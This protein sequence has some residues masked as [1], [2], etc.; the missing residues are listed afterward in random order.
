MGHVVAHVSVRHNNSAFPEPSAYLIF[1]LPAVSCIKKRCQVGAYRVCAAKFTFQIFRDHVSK[2]GFAVLREVGNIGWISLFL[3]PF[4]QEFRLHRFTAAVNPRKDN[5]SSLHSLVSGWLYCYPFCE[6]AYPFGHPDFLFEDPAISRLHFEPLIDDTDSFVIH[7]LTERL[8]LRSV[9]DFISSNRGKKAQK[10]VFLVSLFA[11]NQNGIYPTYQRKND[12]LR[13]KTF[14]RF[15]E[16]KKLFAFDASVILY[17]HNAIRISQKYDVVLP[18]PASEGLGSQKRQE[19]PHF[20]VREFIRFIDQ[21]FR[22]LHPAGKGATLARMTMEDFGR[23]WKRIDEMLG[24]N[25]IEITPLP[26]TS[27]LPGCFRF[28]DGAFELI[29]REFCRKAYIASGNGLYNDLPFG[30]CFWCKR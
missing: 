16:D 22:G 25:K 20:E 19:A 6:A 13:I 29:A 1:T 18:I 23:L 30:R 8:R 11:A 7:I 27:I 2:E 9:S 28:I 21:I 3:Q 24:N 26:C 17:D 4:V 15:P 12:G 10:I 5:Q 14:C